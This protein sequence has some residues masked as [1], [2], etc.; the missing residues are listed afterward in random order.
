MD[1]N[2]T[3]VDPFLTC[4]DKE[5]IFILQRDI[6]QRAIHDP[7][8][9]HRDHPSGTVGIHPMQHRMDGKGILQQTISS[10]NQR[11]DR[12]DAVIQTILTRAEDR[13]FDLYHILITQDILIHSHRVAIGHL[14]ASHIKLVDHIDGIAL[15]SGTVYT[16]RLL[17][18]IRHEATGIFHQGRNTLITAHLVSHRALHETCNI[19]NTVIRPDH[20]HI[21]VS[22]TD[23]TREFA[24]QD[25]VIDIDRRNLTTA[26]E[27][28]HITECTDAVDTTCHIQGMEDGGKSTEGIGTRCYHLTHDVHH[29]RAGL[30]HRQT[31]L[32]TTITFAIEPLHLRL[33]RRYGQTGNLNRSITGNRYGTIGRNRQSICALRSAIYIHNHLI[34]S[35]NHIV[36]RCHNVHVWFKRQSWLIEN[37]TTKNNLSSDCVGHGIGNLDFLT[38]CHILIR[39]GIHHLGIEGLAIGIC[40]E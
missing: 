38:F 5:D 33:S 26:S 29:D 6:S 39:L 9:I 40:T 32:R 31:D 4:R 30:T 36:G 21:I 24:I 15:T 25:I 12:M 8:Y 34:T 2:R 18:G 11:F 28:F 13:T 3:F 19:H 23:I 37:I 22:Q 35:A 16:H 20:D 27:D 10:L 17:I 14:K 1:R 7:L